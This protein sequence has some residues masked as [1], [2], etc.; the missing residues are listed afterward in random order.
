[1]NPSFQNNHP[2]QDP[3]PNNPPFPN[4]Y[5][6]NPPFPNPQFQNPQFQNPPHHNNNNFPNNESTTSKKP[7]WK[8]FKGKYVLI[9][10]LCE[11]CQDRLYHSQDRIMEKEDGWVIKIEMCQDCVDK[12]CKATTALS[13]PYVKKQEEY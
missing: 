4:N 3:F 7:H 5:Q 6:N 11:Q 1:M 13:K 12:N 9:Y 8:L 10:Y 2:Y